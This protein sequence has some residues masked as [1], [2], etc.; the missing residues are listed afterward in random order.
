MNR[1]DWQ[2]MVKKM[3]R[4]CQSIM[5]ITKDLDYDEF[6][7]DT[8][9]YEVVSKSIQQLALTAYDLPEVIFDLYP[10]VDWR[11]LI[12]A[13]YVYDKT[14]DL[15]EITQS[16][17]WPVAQDTIPELLPTLH[18]LLKEAEQEE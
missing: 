6:I 3:V 7:A 5:S 10:K 14:D 1:R 4:I 2:E 13:G 17:I 11:G 8:E 9:S 16:L 12:A 18:Y 15:C